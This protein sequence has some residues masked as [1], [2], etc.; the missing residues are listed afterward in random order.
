MSRTV[1]ESTNDMN[2]EQSKDNSFANIHAI[3]GKFFHK[4]ATLCFVLGHP[5]PSPPPI[6]SASLLIAHCSLFTFV[7][8]KRAIRLNFDTPL[9]EIPE[10]HEVPRNFQET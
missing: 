4:M 5:L 3:R 2:E 9:C 1:L 7:Y 10:F 8:T 6:S